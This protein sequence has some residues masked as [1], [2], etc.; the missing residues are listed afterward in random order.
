MSAFVSR[1]LHAEHVL[2]LVCR[3]S[4]QHVGHCNIVAHSAGKRSRCGGRNAD[5]KA[6]RIVCG[7]GGHGKLLDAWKDIAVGQDSFVASRHEE[8]LYMAENVLHLSFDW[9][10]LFV[11]I[12]LNNADLEEIPT[13]K[14]DDVLQAN[15]GLLTRHL[16][17]DLEVMF[18]A[19]VH[20]SFC[21]AFLV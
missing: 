19:C 11:T 4:S 12:P 8:A 15:L 10:D 5:Q 9:Q 7:K 13:A 20:C 18:S 16:F 14:R 21:A 6:T 17:D 1:Y 2:F 3:G